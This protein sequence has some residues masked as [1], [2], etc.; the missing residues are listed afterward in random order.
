[1][2]GGW[3]R[4]LVFS[5]CAAAAF[6]VVAHAENP[7]ADL[8]KHVEAVQRQILRC[9]NIGALSEGAVNTKVVLGFE[10]TPAGMP[11][12]E[13]VRLINYDGEGSSTDDAQEA[14]VAAR[15]AVLRCGAAGFDL[16]R[17]YYQYW[18]QV[19]MTFA[20]TR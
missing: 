12:S 3:V 5:G 18:R 11:V 4:R 16:P 20:A 9:W 6:G 15:R 19:E 8:A 17:D 10:L 7:P 14:F 13:T 1:M 2:F